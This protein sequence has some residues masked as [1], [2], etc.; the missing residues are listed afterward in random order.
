MTNQIYYYEK[1]NDPLNFCKEKNILILPSENKNFKY[2]LNNSNE[3]IRTEINSEDIL[4]VSDNI[5]DFAV[6]NSFSENSTVKFIYWNT[7]FKGILHYSDYNRETT[8][9]YLFGLILELEENIRNILYKNNYTEIH[10][11]DYLQQKAEY[12]KNEKQ[13]SIKENIFKDAKKRFLS[14]YGKVYPFQVFNLSHTIDFFN[15]LIKKGIL[16]YEPLSYEINEIRNSIMHKKNFIKVLDFEKG[17]FKFDFDSFLSFKKKV[18]T[19]FNSLNN[20]KK[21]N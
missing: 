9:V 14:E 16:N 2:I 19:I 12:E 6:L 20:L 8:Y 18:I 5:F 17:R 4:K 15:H 10:L 13:K 3:F 7:E 21:M 1:L 11:L